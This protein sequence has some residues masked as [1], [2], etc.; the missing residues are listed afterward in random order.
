MRPIVINKDA[1]IIEGLLAGMSGRVIGAD[2]SYN[3]VLI[4]IERGTVVTIDRERVHQD[5]GQV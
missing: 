4:E 3:E 2:A 1:S 5:N